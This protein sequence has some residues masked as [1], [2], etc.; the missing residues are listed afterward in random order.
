M[1]KFFSSLLAVIMLISVFSF[2][3]SAAFSLTTSLPTVSSVEFTNSMPVSKAEVKSFAESGFEDVAMDLQFSSLLYK[4]KAVLSDGRE[5]NFTNYDTMV[6]IEK[7]V[8]LTYTATVS[9]SDYNK[10]VKNKS[11]VNVDFKCTVISFKTGLFSFL[12]QSQTDEQ[13]FTLKRK[14]ANN[15]IKKISYVSGLKS[16]IYKGAQYMDLSGVKFSVEYASGK[17]KTYTCKEI[18]ESDDTYPYYYKAYTLNGMRIDYDIA[19]KGVNFYYGDATKCYKKLTVKANPYKSIKITDYVFDDNKGL[20]SITYKVT[21]KNGNA[22]TY[23][24]DVSGYSDSLFRVPSML[25]N[26][27]DGYF[28]SMSDYNYYSDA[29]L[30]DSENSVTIC[31]M[32]GE[33]ISDSVTF[34]AKEAST[35]LFDDFSIETL[36]SYLKTAL[37]YILSLLGVSL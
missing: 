2:Q 6:E 16:S 24:F 28:V 29:I 11:K 27:F 23:T 14:I 9:L 32:L 30:E 37:S 34:E 4:F 17:K 26:E 3:S 22:N 31:L 5:I 15:Y 1:K 19:K 10:A 35:S 8:Y 7:N 13:S 20:Q 36:F 12:Q 21:K 33:S 18:E 25:I